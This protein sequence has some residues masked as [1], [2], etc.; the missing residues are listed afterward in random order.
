[1]FFVKTPILWL[2]GSEALLVGRRNDK[3][4][5]RSKRGNREKK[6]SNILVWGP[7]H[8][9]HRTICD[10]ASEAAFNVPH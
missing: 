8:T 3:I 10:K 2:S 5:K 6:G 1:M 4:Q 9:D 7:W